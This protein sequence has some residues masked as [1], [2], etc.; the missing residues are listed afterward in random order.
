M[1]T[2]YLLILIILSI[3]CKPENKGLFE[4]DPR[5]LEENE[6]TLSKITDEI[7]YIPLDN[8]F[9]IGQIYKKIKFINNS[10]YLSAKGNGILAFDREGKF[11]RKI[12]S[13]GRGPGEY[14]YYY[15]ITV[16]DKKETIY[17][18]D[19][20]N[21]KVYSKTGDFL[22]SIRLKEY[23]DNIDSFEIYNSKLFIFFLLQV[24]NAKYE[25]IILDTLGNLM[26]KI[27]RFQHLP[28]IGY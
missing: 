8:S 24:D 17:N 16:D 10:I 22:R 23:G 19:Q 18:M 14:A 26:R 9:P 11:V 25:C 4:F 21:I 20:S 13:I 28:V 6:I 27:G 5:S 1:K 2:K 3:S 7:T 12:G 15:D